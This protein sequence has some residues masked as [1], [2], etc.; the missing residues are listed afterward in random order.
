M[1]VRK[2]IQGIVVLKWKEDGGLSRLCYISQGYVLLYEEILLLQ[3]QVTSEA[4]KG[5]C[6]GSINEEKL[7]IHFDNLIIRKRFI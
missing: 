3:T 5:T 1:G 4:L 2:S 7:Q 6:T